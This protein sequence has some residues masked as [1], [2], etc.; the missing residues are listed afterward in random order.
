MRLL[1]CCLLLLALAASLGRPDR[2]VAQSP[3]S[4]TRSLVHVLDY[5]AADYAVAVQDGVIINQAEFAEMVSFAATAQALLG[6]LVEADA[7]ADTSSLQ[8]RLE[9]LAS[10]VD[11]LAHPDSVATLARSIRNDVLGRT[12]I[13]R[14]PVN[15][16]DLA[17]GERIYRQY[18]AACHGAEGAADGPQAAA[19]DPAPT[20]FASGERIASISPF[21]AYNTIRLGVDGTSMIAYDMLSD[22][23]VWEVAFY[24]K[25]LAHRLPTD[26][27]VSR[28]A[29]ERQDVSAW[30]VSLEHVAMLDDMALAAHLATA[31]TLTE[32]SA[33]E[34]VSA[35]RTHHPT[36]ASG[37][38]LDLASRRLDQ[39][40]AAYR[41]G[42]PGEAR[43]HALAA[44]LEGIEPV[45]PAIG[46]RDRTLLI[47]LESRM[48]D[49]RSGIEQR[50]DTGDVAAAVNRALATIEATR[51]VL[52]SGPRSY[53]FSFFVAASILLR[54]GLEAFL[55][56]LA[57]LSVLQAANQARAARW[58]HAGWLAAVGVGVAG[59]ILSDWLLQI[60]AAQRE[61]M[62][63]AIALVAVAVLMYVG[64]WLHS[65][66]ESKKWR[67]FIEER[68]LHKL[69]TGSL[70]GLA[71]IA[72]F[73]VFREAFESVLFLSALTL[74]Q[75]DGHKLAVVGGAVSAI[76]LILALAPLALRHSMRLPVRQVF[77][78]S[79][80]VMA[81]LCVMLAG[82]GIHALQEAGLVS[83]TVL[84]APLRFSL[85]GVYPSMET[86]A[87][88]LV[89]V[90]I[91]LAT[92]LARR[93]SRGSSV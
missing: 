57:I 82:K 12:D 78:Y 53:W 7:L 93:I 65:M 35:L 21:Q 41:A 60:G 11:A 79:S 88:Q 67:A 24:V 89:V 2:A 4:V 37:T 87:A 46:A 80:L 74:E 38:G 64:L 40:L 77:R 62:E 42:N 72:F 23:E 22:A 68:I 18:C 3:E 16:P 63:G 90:T 71:S 83:V 27:P 10:R 69:G 17:S 31:D 13:L 91:L 86:V 92:V 55:I 56:I 58:V 9:L 73:A 70:V 50:A 47:E 45:E 5:M 29:A 8:A 30:P 81:V 84:N 26:S 66:T 54:E 19:L 75:G 6:D 33:V 85:L 32:G 14:A 59:W 15:W 76:A 25:S 39:A 1:S 20:V 49:V 34:A 43:Q 52:D 36:M 51:D 28:A 48:M 61:I 44:Y